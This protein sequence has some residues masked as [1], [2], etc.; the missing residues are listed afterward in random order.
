MPKASVIVPAFNAVSTI[1]ETLASLQRQ[2]FED[3]EIIV[4]DD[5]STDETADLVRSWQSDPRIRLVQQAN[6]GL[7]GARN[8][9]IAAARG[10]Y[11]GLCDADDVW[12]PDKLMRHV[13]HLDARPHVGVSYSGS[14]LMDQNGRPISRTQTPRLRGITA[15]HV[16][17]RNPVG[18]GSASV[19]RRRMLEAMAFRPKQ[20]F[21]RDWYFDETFRQSED[22][23]FWLRI[24]LRSDWGFE[25]VPGLLTGY[26]I[27]TNGLSADTDRQFKSWCRMVDKLRPLD[28]YFFKRHEPAARAYQY[29]YLARRAVSGRD[30]A[31][32]FELMRKSL[33]SSLRPVLE[34]PIKTISTL[35]AAGIFAVAGPK[36]SS[37]LPGVTHAGPRTERSD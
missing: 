12:Q 3:M 34:E 32:A 35:L 6:R 1:P 23:E 11:L 36:V 21:V 29:R 26:R 33:S 22:I 20:E 15:A 8:T 7:A 13:R 17:K 30:G 16:F 9:G 25:G 31:R 5:G 10:I 24:T 2:S 4:V 19:L 37:V 14:Y 18:N 27:N 28:P